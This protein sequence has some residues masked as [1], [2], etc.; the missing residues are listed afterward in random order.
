MEYRLRQVRGAIYRILQ[1]LP[2]DHPNLFRVNRELQGSFLI[3]HNINY[4]TKKPIKLM[5]IAIIFE[6]IPKSKY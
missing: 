4:V 3:I 6:N 5:S 2:K 1:T